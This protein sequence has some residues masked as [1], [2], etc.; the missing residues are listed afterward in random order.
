MVGGGGGG[1]NSL[2][3][4]PILSPLYACYAGYGTLTIVFYS[5]ER[6]L[7]FDKIVSKLLIKIDNI[8]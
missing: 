1:K 8:R 3:F 7:Q 2:P 4:F 6:E 5:I